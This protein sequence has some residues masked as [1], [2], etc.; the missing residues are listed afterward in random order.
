MT[1]MVANMAAGAALDAV[2]DLIVVCDTGGIIVHVNRAFCDVMDGPPE[3]WPGTPLKTGKSDR[4]VPPAGADAVQFEGRLDTRD[5]PRRIAWQAAGLKDGRGAAVAW[6]LSG[7]D[8]TEAHLELDY[9]KRQCA[10][11]NAASQAKSQFLATMGH[12]VR[13]PL[14]G[15]LGMAGLLADTDLNAEQQT[16]TAAIRDSGNA[17]LILI[18]D[19]LDYSK[20]EAGKM[21]LETVDFD[22]MQTV[23]GIAELLAPRAFEKKLHIAYHVDSGTP[24][25]LTGDEARL[26]QVILNLAGNAV[27]FTEEGGVGIAVSGRTAGTGSDDVT[28]RI[29]VTDTGIG[30]PADKRERIFE[31]FEQADSSHARKYEGTGLGLAICRK[32]VGSMGGRIHV[33]SPEAGGS[34]FS[35]TVQMKQQD[36]PAP[37]R[38]PEGLLGLKVLV[39][40]AEDMTR[41]AIERQLDGPGIEVVG[42]DGGKAALKAVDEAPGRLFTTLICDARLPDMTASD[43]LGQVTRRY[44][45]PPRALVMLT[46]RE[47]GKLDE[48][49]SRGFDAYLIKPLRQD[50]FLHRIERVHGLA[51][52]EEDISRDVAAA[53]AERT[54]RE[55]T[56]AAGRR[57]RVLLAEDNQVNAM[58]PL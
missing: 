13:T 55:P 16:Y 22:I 20:L 2:A 6:V 56:A 12:E 5:G 29:E 40:T 14:N 42:V 36:D 58:P 47:R 43:L 33:V 31:E 21:K 41:R 38:G 17:L 23:Q 54:S 18:N 28:L 57:L 3:S 8:V 4:F 27:K 39:A 24:T 52:S 45:A 53:E 11:A 32:I 25:R 10:D 26:R 19:I 44:D 49:L 46:P 51:V 34:A 35:F 30:I 37:V 48:L 15:I 50:S 7:R 1:L 9:F